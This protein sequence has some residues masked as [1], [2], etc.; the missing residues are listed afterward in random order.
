MKALDLE[1]KLKLSFYFDQGVETLELA[2]KQRLKDIKLKILVN[3]KR[4]FTNS[5]ICL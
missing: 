1:K 2:E 5:I 3:D 4:F